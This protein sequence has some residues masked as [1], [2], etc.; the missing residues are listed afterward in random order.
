M[1]Y[2]QDQLENQDTSFANTSEGSEIH[3]S[4]VKYGDRGRGPG[5]FCIGC[6]KQMQ[7]MKSSIKQEYFRHDYFASKGQPKCTYSDETYR[8]KIAKDILQISKRIKVPAVYKFSPD[9]RQ[10]E[11]HTLT[12]AH[13]IEAHKAVIEHFIYET[14]DGSIAFS[15]NKQGEEFKR[16]I[17]KP[18][19]LFLDI[20]NKPLLIIEIVATHKPNNEKLLKLKRLGIDAVQVTIPRNSREAIAKTFEHTENTKWIYNHEEERTDYFQLSSTNIAGIQHIDV[21]QRKLF[22]ENYKCRSA[23]IG[24]L[25]RRIENLLGDE[26]YQEIERSIRSEIQLVEDNTKGNRERLAELREQ[27]GNSGIERYHERRASFKAEERKEQENYTKLEARYLDK[28]RQLIDQQ[29]SVESITDRE[30]QRIEREKSSVSIALEEIERAIKDQQRVNEES[31]DSIRRIH[32]ATDRLRENNSA[33]ESRFRKE[34]QRII[35][36]LSELDNLVGTLPAKFENEN[37]SLE[38]SIQLQQEQIRKE[39]ETLDGRRE[40]L[41]TRSGELR[42][43]ID[44]RYKQIRAELSKQTTVGDLSIFRNEFTKQYKINLEVRKAG[45]DYLETLYVLE[46]IEKRK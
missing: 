43:E 20:K 5:Y 34:E 19:V 4:E 31:E 13:Y 42:T 28:R 35:G 45:D 25:I 44:Q 23:Q 9:K 32:D 2:F 46:R 40:K 29:K 18:D 8:H 36:E 7:A 11:V 14:N 38:R 39:E 6:T 30:L 1:E 33:D 10:E 37:A 3:I 24:S 22:E 26:S 27:Y 21:D 12:K 16:M 17:I 41:T 15:D